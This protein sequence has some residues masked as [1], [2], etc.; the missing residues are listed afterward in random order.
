M[1]P[2]ADSNGDQP[3]HRHRPAGLHQGAAAEIQ[4][5]RKIPRRISRLSPA[6]RAVAVRAADARKRRRPMPT[7]RLNLNLLQAPSMGASENSTGCRSTTFT[8]PF[9]RSELRDVYRSSRIGW[10]T[11][12]MDGMNLVAKEY[13]ACQDPADPG[14]L[15]SVEIRG[16]RGATVRRPCSLI[17]MTSA[18]WCRASGVAVEMPLDER[19]ARHEKLVRIVHESDSD[20]WSRSYFSALMKAGQRRFGRSGKSSPEMGRALERL[21]IA[22]KKNTTGNRLAANV[23]R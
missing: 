18:L 21:Q 15:I 23:G 17:P 20:A 1:L 19:R 22:G 9:P 2:P 8:G 11:P 4:V 7:S 13:I 14:V 5:V 10:V 16:C 6:H 12:L 3:H